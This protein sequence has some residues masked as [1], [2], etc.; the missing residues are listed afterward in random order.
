MGKIVA[1][2]ARPSVTKKKSFMALAPSSPRAV[3]F[4]EAAGKKLGK[5]T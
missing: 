4:A 5:K 2:Y 1:Y 3:R